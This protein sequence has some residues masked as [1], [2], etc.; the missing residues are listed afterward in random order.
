MRDVDELGSVDL[1]AALFQPGREDIWI[2]RRIAGQ[3]PVEEVED[4]VEEVSFVGGVA[5]RPRED[6]PVAASDVEDAAARAPYLVEKLAADAA[7]DA[8]AAR[9]LAAIHYG[10]L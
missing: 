5:V 7:V 1:L 6:D 10:V 2:E 3:G 4:V 8:L 9:R